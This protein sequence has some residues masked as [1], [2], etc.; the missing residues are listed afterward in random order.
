MRKYK[1]CSP[2]ALR[3]SR[4]FTLVELLVVIAII[5]I[6]A[7]LL[8]PAVSGARNQG[9]VTA[10]KSNL[11]QLHVAAN[12]YSADNDGEMVMPFT[13]WGV[14]RGVNYTV[15]LIP[16]IGAVTNNKM[17]IMHCPTQFKAMRQLPQLERTVFTYSENH[18]ITSEAFG[19]SERASGRTNMVP[20]NVAWFSANGVTTPTGRRVASRST[21]PYFMDGWHRNTQGAF[22]SWRVWAHYGYILEGGAQAFADSW[23]HKGKTS[24]VFLDGHVEL[25]G[26]GDGIWEG[27]GLVYDWNKQMQWEFTQ[28]SM[29]DTPFREIV[30]AF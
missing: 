17:N 26:I 25:N 10:C 4:G 2:R 21:V 29:G 20:A 28:G 1:I 22:I 18:Q 3:S 7:A 19:Y 12:Q 5:A 15:G 13:G 27:A 23:P 8:F 16:Y 30:N 11:R 9:E 6:L 14:S 24:V